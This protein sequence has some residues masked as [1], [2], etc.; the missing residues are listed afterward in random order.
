MRLGIVFMTQVI[1]L[2]LAGVKAPTEEVHLQLESEDDGGMYM[3]VVTINILQAIL[4][5][6][7]PL[8]SVKTCMNNTMYAVN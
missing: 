4:S 8:V 1:V 2:L 5:Q 3:G 6:Y 7:M